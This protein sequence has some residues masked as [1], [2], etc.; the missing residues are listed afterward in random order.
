MSTK[1]GWFSV[2]STSATVGLPVV[3]VVAGPRLHPIARV[4]PTSRQA[5]FIRSPYGD[6]EGSPYVLFFVYVR[7]FLFNTVSSSTATTI[8]PPITICWR[9]DDTPSRLRP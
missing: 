3:L 9:K 7:F 6:P 2:L 8:T 1:K 4:M 5:L